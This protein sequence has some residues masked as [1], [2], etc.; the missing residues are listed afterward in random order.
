MGTALIRE[1]TASEV[2]TLIQGLSWAKL[3][4]ENLKQ[5]L[6][7]NPTVNLPAKP[8]SRS[9]QQQIIAIFAANLG[10]G[11]NREQLTRIGAALGRTEGDAIQWA[12]KI[13]RVGLK[14]HKTGTKLPAYGL[15]ELLFSPKYLSSGQD[16]T[17]EAGRKGSEDRLRVYFADLSTGKFERGHR[18]PNLPLA[19][20]NLVMQPQEINRSYRDR[21]LFDANGLPKAPNPVKFIGDPTAYYDSRAYIEMV[22]KGLAAWLEANPEAAIPDADSGDGEEDTDE[23]G[24]E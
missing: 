23:D 8:S 19:D 20:E 10:L 13:E 22:A 18:D 15:Q 5:F 2:D 14:L 1:A 24:K 21:F 4:P 7:Q 9:M 16:L 12:N 3:W 11:F 6:A 17:T